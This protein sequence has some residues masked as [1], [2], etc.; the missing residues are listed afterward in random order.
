MFTA[1][2]V[3]VALLRQPQREVADARVAVAASH[4]GGA[5]SVNDSTDREYLLEGHANF[6]AGEV[7]AEAEVHA[8]TEGQVRVGLT[9]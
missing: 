9:L 6:E 3:V 5:A 4:C 2:V 7:C 1:A 8:V